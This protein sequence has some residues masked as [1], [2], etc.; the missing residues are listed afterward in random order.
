[1]TMMLKDPSRHTF[2]VPTALNL[3]PPVFLTGSNVRI[4][5]VSDGALPPIPIA[6]SIECPPPPTALVE[7][8]RVRQAKQNLPYE[9]F[10]H[11]YG[12]RSPPTL[13]DLAPYV[14]RKHADHLLRVGH[15]FVGKDNKTLRATLS[16]TEIAHDCHVVCRLAGK[17]TRRRMTVYYPTTTAYL[18]PRP[19]DG[20]VNVGS[21]ITCHADGYPPPTLSLRLSQPLRPRKP[22][23]PEEIEA[24]RKGG[25]IPRDN[26]ITD[27]ISKEMMLAQT[28]LDI[29]PQQL[30]PP[31]PNEA[32]E[33]EPV[34]S[35][36]TL[37]QVPVG[38]HDGWFNG[39]E[40]EPYEEAS[41]IPGSGL[42]AVPPHGQL[43]LN[44]NE[45]SIQ[46]ATFRLAPNATP[47]VELMLTCL[48]RNT[49][50][51]DT[52]FLSLNGTVT[53]MRFVVA[54]ISYESLAVALGVCAC[55][56]LI[57]VI[58]IVAMLLQKR[59]QGAS[60]GDT[61]RLTANGTKKVRTPYTRDQY[62]KAS[63]A[64]A[65]REVSAPS[66]RLRLYQPNNVVEVDSNMVQTSPHVLDS[67][68]GYD[69]VYPSPSAAAAPVASAAAAI[70]TG[71][72]GV[73]RGPV[74]RALSQTDD[75]QLQYAELAFDQ[76]RPRPIGR[77]GSSLRGGVSSTSMTLF[78]SGPRHSQ[79]KRSF[80]ASV[81][82]GLDIGGDGGVIR[83]LKQ[84]P[85]LPESPNNET[86]QYTEIV[87]FMQPR[88]YSS[89]LVLQQQQ[90]ATQALLAMQ[91]NKPREFV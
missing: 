29:I 41:R 10:Y 20:Y 82:Q 23:S 39:L 66:A 36:G 17:E 5:C 68:Y 75:P 88:A 52:S 91:Q 32:K 19:R 78:G 4:E 84:S 57:L 72:G 8:D 33:S 46:G 7:L 55:V 53:R 50:P 22:L 48:A 12:F 38:T 56:L 63:R 60:G 43:G 40:K 54:A 42:S 25:L 67:D 62:T 18:L 49:L 1:M 9:R 6:F 70:V 34:A 31:G 65:A 77:A 16:I 3:R 85:P 2:N 80:G 30:N 73:G 26:E 83:G 14:A 37:H 69:A 24:L 59:R 44:P 90:E 51:G 64:P 28:G 27:V 58:I 35:S 89:Q 15:V 76:A 86:S 13:S 74:E 61:D 79:P 45:Y 81:P 47:G 87:G 21:E 71:T 11:T